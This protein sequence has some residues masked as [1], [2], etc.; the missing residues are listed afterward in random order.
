MSHT[1]RVGFLGAGGWGTALACLLARHPIDIQLWSF[2]ERAAAVMNEQREN[3]TYLPGVAIPDAIHIT[4]D[5]NDLRGCDFLVLATPTQFVRATLER[6]GRELVGDAAVINV[7]KGIETT[8]LKRIS[9]IVVEAWGLPRDR[10]AVLSGP[11]HAE[12]VARGVPTAVV[13]ASSSDALAKRVQE[14]FFAP[15]FRVY[16][17]TD[18]VGVELCA[19]LKNVIALSAGICDG[20][21]FGDNTKATLITRGLAEMTRMGLALGAQMRTFSGLS[22]LGDLIVTCNSRHS[23]NRYVGEQIGKGRSLDAV[24]AEM[25]MVA[26]GVATTESAFR[27]AKSIGVEMPIVNAVHQ[28]LFEG[29]DPREATRDLMTREM[30]EE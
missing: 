12:E 16:S 17:S 22:G 28:I 13:V 6:A 3:I 5:L 9:E 4:T 8:T 21:G 2:D 23:R 26:E 19:A 29:K 7:A 14:L 18:V 11:S 24:L 25:K 30:K 27:L 1:P 10:Y 20:A 15:T